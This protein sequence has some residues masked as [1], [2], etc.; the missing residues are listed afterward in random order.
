MSTLTINTRVRESVTILDL[1]GRLVLGEASAA[2]RER[3]RSLLADDNKQILVNL[4]TVSYID[5]S[6]VGELVSGYATANRNAG[7]LK[8]LNLTRSV[9][10]L[11][12]LTKL[13]TVFE[14]FED[15]DAA[16][17]SFGSSQA[18]SGE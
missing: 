1:E 15:E 10:D 3:V 12:Q 14:V 9:E 13:L 11:L 6:G 18:A 17:A 2:F 8:L 5:S 16:V 7:T 4:A